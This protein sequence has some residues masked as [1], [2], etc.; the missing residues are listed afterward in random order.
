MHYMDLQVGVRNEKKSS[1]D[2][3]TDNQLRAKLKVQ[4]T[5][6]TIQD[7]YWN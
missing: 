5:K 4:P 2:V 1:R 6:I 3:L 7:D